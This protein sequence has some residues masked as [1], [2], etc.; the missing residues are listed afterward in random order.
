M[1][2]ELGRTI[3]P[4]LRQDIELQVIELLTSD[5]ATCQTLVINLLR[6]IE[7]QELE[8]LSLPSELNLQRQV[9]IF[10]WGPVWLY[11]QLV[12]LCQQAPWVATYDLR[13]HRGIVVSSRVAGIAPGDVVPIQ[14]SATPGPAIL[15]GGPPKSGK[16]V[17]SYALNRCLRQGWP[18]LKTHLF[19]ANWD[20]EGNHT[21]ETPDRDLAERL[22]QENNPKLQQQADYAE[23]IARFFLKKGEELPNVRRIIDLTLVDV[24]GK[25]DPDRLPVVQQCTHYIVISHDPQEVANWHALCGLSVKPLAVI[26]SV[27]E[28]R[29]EVLRREPFLEVVAGPWERGEVCKVPGILLKLVVNLLNER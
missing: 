6:K 15:I 17:L 8:T 19:R 18:G 12:T 29:L 28:P 26:H 20:G 9:L 2:T 27:Q 10:G 5:G 24:G 22:R 16:S 23:K 11:G 21:Y 14:Q 1:V 7:P 4:P 25:T 13:S 3:Q